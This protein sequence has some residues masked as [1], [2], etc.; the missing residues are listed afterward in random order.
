[1]TYKLQLKMISSPP[2]RGR[3][4]SRPSR[5]VLNLRCAF[6][7]TTAAPV[8]PQPFFD[9]AVPSLD[10]E[11]S[12]SEA[13]L[14]FRRK[15]RQSYTAPSIRDSGTL[16]PG[17]EWYPAWMKYRRR[18]SNYV[19][20]Q[21]KF[22]R[23]SIDIPDVEKRWTLFSTVWFILMEFKFLFI[24]PALRFLCFLAARAIM[25]HIYAAHKAFILWQCKMEAYLAFWSTDGKIGAFSKSMAL[26]RLHWK[27]CI[28]GEALYLINILKTGRVH[29]LPPVKRPSRRPTFFFLF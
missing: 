7:S 11:V 25:T 10:S 8:L 20:W 4:V 23:C 15:A 21:E 6:A 18:E 27:N 5:N 24:P 9:P 26:R 17:P 28:L 12:T 14:A 19:F 13:A 16:R 3:I 22:S 2:L 1:M 29:L